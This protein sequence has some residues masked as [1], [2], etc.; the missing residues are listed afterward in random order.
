MN[1]L[2][3]RNHN[4]SAQLEENLAAVSR[5]T[6]LTT[7]VREADMS[8]REFT[9]RLKA[10]QWNGAAGPNAVV[11]VFQ[12]ESDLDVLASVMQIAQRDGCLLFIFIPEGT[13]LSEE[14]QLSVE[15]QV[16][17]QISTSFVLYDVPLEYKARETAVALIQ[18]TQQGFF[19][20]YRMVPAKH[21]SGLDVVPYLR[22][23]KQ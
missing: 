8:L 6:N 2:I 21:G 16:L 5:Q 1:L 15:N 18:L 3:V 23:K 19:G 11:C 9:F 20:R 12:Q 14:K 22:R 4:Q 7:M 10:L 13:A 17:D